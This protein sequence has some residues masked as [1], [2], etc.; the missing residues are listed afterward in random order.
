MLEVWGHVDVADVC[1]LNTV[2]E[3][4]GRRHFEE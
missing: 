2:E 3:G 1:H 4:Y